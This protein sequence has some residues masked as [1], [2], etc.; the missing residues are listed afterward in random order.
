MHRYHTKRH[1]EMTTPNS[2][3][4]IAAMTSAKRAYPERR[5][6]I[7]ARLRVAGYAGRGD[8]DHRDRR[9][10]LRLDRRL[11][12]DERADDADRVAYWVGQAKSGLLQK[13]KGDEHAD[14]LQR[15][16]KRNV[17]LRRNDR[18]QKLRRDHLLMIHGYGRV[19]CRQRQRKDHRGPA[20]D[21]QR[22]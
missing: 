18:E 11:A 2:P 8:N 4:A 10:D 19:K 9:Y 7:L 5:A 3:A 12:D 22:G 20:D 21:A 16:R 17:L 14:K 13:L 1:S 15:R 6:E